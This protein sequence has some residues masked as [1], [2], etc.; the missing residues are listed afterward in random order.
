MNELGQLNENGGIATDQEYVNKA[1]AI[2]TELEISQQELRN[3][4][5]A[6]VLRE[7]PPNA[8]TP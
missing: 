5:I 3:R 6:D 2:R 4:L 8:F 7:N 1:N